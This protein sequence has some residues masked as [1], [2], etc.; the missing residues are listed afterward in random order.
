[1]RW[2]F[3]FLLLGAPACAGRTG[4]SQSHD[5][6]GTSTAPNSGGG[7]SAFDSGGRTGSGGA[8]M[9]N[10]GDGTT[11]SPTGGLVGLGGSDASTTM[12]EDDADSTSS[13][14]GLDTVSAITV[15]DYGLGACFLTTD[16]SATCWLGPAAPS[17]STFTQIDAGEYF[18]CGVKTDGSAVCWGYAGVQAS[19]PAPQP[20]PVPM[21]K[22]ARAIFKAVASSSTAPLVVGAARP[23]TKTS[24]PR[25]NMSR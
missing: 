9:P 23:L 10:G 1:M 13:D 17:S 20:R 3:I 4:I 5:A 18:S 8:I 21:P 22:S 12:P 25:G 7:T 6:S 24:R 11:A 19:D 2:L 16:G 15:S 14:A